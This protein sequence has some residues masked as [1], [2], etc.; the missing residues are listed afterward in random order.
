MSPIRAKELST[1]TQFEI[2]DRLSE[3]HAQFKVTA[4]ACSQSPL[5]NIHQEI[6]MNTKYSPITA[7]IREP[8]PVAF[9]RPL[10]GLEH[11][12]WMIDQHRP[13]HFAMA[14]HIEGRTTISAWRAALGA[15]QERH[16]LLSVAI[17]TMANGGP[18]FRTVVDAPIPLRITKAPLSSWQTEVARE[19]ATPFN[20]EQTPLVRAGLLHGLTESVLILSAH[21]SI[22]DGLSVAYLVRDT[23][24]ALAGEALEPLAPVPAEEPLVYM[25]QYPREDTGNTEQQEP[26]PEGRPVTFRELHHSLPGIDALRLSPELTGKLIERARKERTTVHGARCSALVL[27]GREASDEWIST[28][29]RVLSPF[30]LRK[31][32]GVGEDRG[33]FVWGA[34]VAMRPGVPASFWEMARFAKSSLAARQSMERVAMEMQGVEQAMGSGIDVP[35][36]AQILSQGFP[37]EVFLTNL[38][39]LSLQFDCGDLKLKELWGPAVLMGFEGE[40]TVGVSTVNG[41]LCMLHTSFAPL[42]LLLQRA[43]RILRFACE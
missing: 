10:G 27:A 9:E 38:G 8:G 3:L 19:L 26:L 20:A 13:V 35:G 30:N 5:P 39:N 1:E 6:L 2:L 21:H 31:Q 12:F 15:V 41:S 16:P 14:A 29:V 32:I 40:Q 33:V 4:K 22:A 23:V 11:F 25:S 42:P 24:H 18:S 43:E 28:P 7:T 37:C 34:G 36:A 17:K